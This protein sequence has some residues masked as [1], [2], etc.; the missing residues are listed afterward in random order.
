MKKRI[1]CG[2]IGTFVFLLLFSVSHGAAFAEAET[3]GGAGTETAQSGTVKSDTAQP[4]PVSSENAEAQA[5]SSAVLP[6]G[7]VQTEPESISAMTADGWQ[8]I[9][10]DIYYYTSGAPRTGWL[11]TSTD[12]SGVNT[13]AQRYWLAADGKLAV[14]RI[15]TETEAGY[16]AYATSDG[17]VVR[18]K[19]AADGKIFLASNDGKLENTGWLVTDR[20]GSG[21][22]RY[23]IDPVLHC[24]STD[25]F[26]VDGKNY[27]GIPGDGYVLRGADTIGGSRYYAD[28]GGVLVEK[29]WVV[30]A[31][32][33][34]DL[35]R[36]WFENG[37][38]ASEGVYEV[39]SNGNHT[40][41]RP[42]GYVVRGRYVSSE[43]KVYLA[44][45]D[46]RLEHDGWRVTD[47][48]DGGLQRYYIDSG[49]HSASIGIF[50][51][52]GKTYYGIANLGYVVRG[53]WKENGSLY[54]ADNSGALLENGWLVTDEYGQGLQRYWF[55]NGKSAPAGLVQIDSA[56]HYAYVRPEGYVARGKYFA[57]DGTI[58]LSDDGVLESPGWHVTDAYDNGL[59][60]YYIDDTAHSAKTGFFDVSG[61]KY[62]G[63]SWSGYVARN[64]MTDQGVRYYADNGGVIRQDGWLVTDEFGQGLQRYWISGGAVA[65]EGLYA[66]DTEGHYTYVQPEGYVVRGKYSAGSGMVYLA[67]NGGILE[68]T[69]WLVTARYDGGYQRYYIDPSLHGASTG[70]FTI[71]GTDYYGIPSKGYV[72]RGKYRY[73]HIG[74]LLA[75]NGGALCTFVSGG[76]LVTG[77]YDGGELQ[78]YRIDDCCDGHAGAHLLSFRLEDLYYGE[79]DEG[80]V[81]RNCIDYIDGTWYEADNEGVLT[82]TTPPVLAQ[83]TSMAQGYASPT[84]YLIMVDKSQF[85]FAVFTGSSYSWTPLYFWD[86]GIGAPWSPTIEGVF[87]MGLKEPSF[88]HGY[89]CYWASQILGDYL[90]HS[91]LYYEGTMDPMFIEM[92]TATS[93]GCVRLE[94]D[95]AY[96]VYWNVPSGT[97]IVIYSE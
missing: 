17:T 94:Y 61:K 42:E 87:H 70:F 56:G 74:M 4:D 30:T 1:F 24:A 22:Q 64:A 21:M 59:Q 67:D 75:D 19:C 44:D 88:G 93:G 90:I 52:A 51:V 89:T 62:Y 80:Y 58:Y 73:N 65:P 84:Q 78:R 86:C 91:G 50:S 5:E 28:N 3:M 34:Q 97:T 77:K 27:Y 12:P 36:Y 79:P 14:S 23:Y 37:T 8:T 60:R 40:Y 46:G 43:G 57:S 81:M 15:V 13:G 95:N 48:Y 96:W 25:F 76:W 45:N 66:V 18:G 39:D 38:C 31:A 69:G 10:G 16:W 7:T 53:A 35:Q 54:Y 47:R 85:K 68:K 32:F 41:V 26:A 72:V 71:D 6:A 63:L 49:T 29:G 9:G 83:M 33:G 20:Y 92:R 2:L 11:V 82:V 55:A